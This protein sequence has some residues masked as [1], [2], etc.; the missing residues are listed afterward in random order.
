MKMG[1]HRHTS[2]EQPESSFQITHISK[3]KHVLK[4]KKQKYCKMIMR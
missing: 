4:K 2:E 3:V 1:K